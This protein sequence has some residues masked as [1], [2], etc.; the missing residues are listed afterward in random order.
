[1]SAV[2]GLVV[3]IRNAAYFIPVERVGFVA[4]AR[5]VRGGRLV[6]PRGSIPYVDP[7][8]GRAAGPP[9]TAVTFATDRGFV[10]VG[11]DRVDLAGREE[12]AAAAPIAAIEDILRSRTS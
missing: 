8:S 4:P 2:A 5:N 9:R 1:M 7:G 3:R 6:M 10:A 12:A 11:V